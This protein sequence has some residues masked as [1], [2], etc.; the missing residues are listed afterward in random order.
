MIVEYEITKN[1]LNAFNLF[2]LS[3]STTAR[4]QYYCSWFIPIVIWLLLF[5][6]C[7][8]VD[9][10]SGTPLRTFLALLPL[11]S[12]VPLYLIFF[13]LAYRR[14]IR[15]TVANMVSEGQNRGLFGRH[16]VVISPESVTESGEFGQSSTTWR[17]VER[18]VRTGDHAFI[19]TNALAAIIVPRR[20][21]GTESE[22]VEF[23]R[24]A[25]EHREKAAT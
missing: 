23:I 9:W 2:H 10:D 21:F 11:L 7:N 12:F 13:P 16:R 19:Y 24:T 25:S 14:H 15:K 5:T 22:F 20:A 17:A 6:C 4:R 18:V 8:L 1:D 3:H